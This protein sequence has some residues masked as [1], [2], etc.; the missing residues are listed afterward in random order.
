MKELK[1]IYKKRKKQLLPILFGFAAVFIIFR[2]IMPQW[3]D[4]AE[5]LD[6]ISTKQEVIESKE[7][8]LKLLASIPDE[9]VNDD[10]DLATT[11]LPTQKDIIL[12]FNELNNAADRANVSLGGF[13]VNLGGIYS[14][15]ERQS[16]VENSIL[17]VP[18]LNILVSVS[19]VN[20]NIKQFAE[21][22]YQSIPLLEIL[23]VNIGN[24][25]A[26]YDVNFFYKPIVLRPAGAESKALEQ[27]TPQEQKQLDELRTWRQN[28]LLLQ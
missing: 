8:T 20:Q 26:K 10:Y 22:L 19:G 12:I 24:D 13:S 1:Q 23:S 15:D 5:V 2:V 17:G 16:K 27:Y 21:E 9:N 11:A 25:D 7:K 14:T 28:S 4:I 18:Y 3:T 6:L